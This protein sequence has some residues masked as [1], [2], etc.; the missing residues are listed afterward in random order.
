MHRLTVAGVT[1]SIYGGLSDLPAFNPAAKGDASVRDLRE[2]IAA[3]EA[4]VFC[5]PECAGTLPGSLKNLLDWLVGSGELHGK[6]VGWINAA[7]PGRGEGAQAT[8]AVALGYGGAVPVD[9]ACLRLEGASHACG[10]DGL[11]MD[12]DMQEKLAGVLQALR[13]L[14]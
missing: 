13:A 3:A 14:G 1:T 6:P 12:V 7:D 8:L 11:I 10:E 9:A 4:G 2:A 5:T